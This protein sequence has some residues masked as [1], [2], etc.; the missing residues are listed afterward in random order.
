MEKVR[1]RREAGMTRCQIRQVGRRERR[2]RQRKWWKRQMRGRALARMA[3]CSR[4]PSAYLPRW[5]CGRPASPPLWSEARRRGVGPH[6]PPQGRDLRSPTHF[7]RSWGSAPPA[8]LGR[9]DRRSQ[10]SP[11]GREHPADALA[12]ALGGPEARVLAGVR[13]RAYEARPEGRQNVWSAGSRT[14]G[15]GH[16]AAP[17]RN[18]RP[19]RGALPHP[20]LRGGATEGREAPWVADIRAG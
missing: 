4:R 5:L 17:A 11:V 15:A 10:G 1:E 20:P 18:H 6:G 3:V 8:P 12:L 19:A 14:I 13:V 7:V 2:E 9:C 16:A